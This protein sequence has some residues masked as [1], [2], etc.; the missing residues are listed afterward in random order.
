MTN[1]E[2]WIVISPYVYISIH[3]EKYLLYNT[4]NGEYIKGC[5]KEIAEII[6]KLI[7]DNSFWMC[8]LSNDSKIFDQFVNELKK[9]YIGDRIEAEFIH[10]AIQ[11]YPIKNIQ[12]DSRRYKGEIDYNIGDSVIK[13]FHELSVY[14]NTTCQH[15]CKNCDKYYKQ[16]TFCHK[17]KKNVS[18]DKN[19]LLSFLNTTKLP[20]LYRIN[21]LGGNI[22]QYQD[23]TGLRDGLSLIGNFDLFFYTNILNFDLRSVNNFSENYYC[24]VLVEINENTIKEKFY[25]NDKIQY[26]L[27]VTNDNTLNEAF[28][29]IDTYQLANYRIKPLYNGSNLEFFKQNVYITEEDILERVHPFEDIFRN[30]TLNCNYFGNLSISADGLVYSNINQKPLGSIDKNDIGD[31][32]EEELKTGKSWFKVHKNLQS[33][34]SCVFS[35]LCS[36]PSNIEKA[37]RRNNLCSVNI[38]NNKI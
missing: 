33:C 21:I 1:K 25:A 11:S 10:S 16:Y 31:I 27:F 8:P 4:I 12:R 30:D 29:I 23:L 15:N 7:K 13:Y 35:N 6:R 26:H 18:L 32:I 20:S 17:T 37:L 24:V 5:N 9:K 2:Y 22:W 34:K 14:V 3:S 36:P 28:R 19:K 38:G